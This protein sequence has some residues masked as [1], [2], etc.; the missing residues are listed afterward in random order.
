MK[1]ATSVTNRQSS[2]HA[3]DS[4]PGMVRGGAAALAGTAAAAACA[5]TW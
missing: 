1:S 5:L 4:L 2:D 3:R